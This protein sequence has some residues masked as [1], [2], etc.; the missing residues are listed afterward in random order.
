VRVAVYTG[1]SPG[2]AAHADAAAKF[3]QRLAE[4]GLGIVYG[5][6]KAGLMGIVADAALAAGGEVI[7]VIPQHMMDTE[8]GHHGLTRLE[9]VPG[10]HERKARM[11]EQ[12]DAF[13]VLPGGAGTM[14]EFFEVWTW[15]QLGLHAKPVAL[16][17]VDGFYRPLLDQLR[18]MSRAGYITESYLAS[19][20]RVGN[21]DEFLS[22]VAGYRPPPLKWG[23]RQQ[24]EDLNS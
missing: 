18:A 19:L 21:A 17:D 22:F 20:G 6:G 16:I 13:A 3:G 14:E 2:P 11:A 15:G 12:A 4:A 8:I 24:A 5:G 9:I 7:G 10:M 1:S 23:Q